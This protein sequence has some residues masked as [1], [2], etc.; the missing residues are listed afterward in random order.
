MT[1]FVE[2]LWEAAFAVTAAI[3]L[4][5]DLNKNIICTAIA[6]SNYFEKYIIK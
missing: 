5:K 6:A 4:T 2:H 1:V 3:C